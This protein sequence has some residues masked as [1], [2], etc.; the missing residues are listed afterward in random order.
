MTW[1]H[2]MGS[3]LV[4]LL[5]IGIGIYSGKHV[6]TS[7]NSNKGR[8][9]TTGLVTGALLGTLVGGSSTI[10]T[11]QLAYTY[12]FSAWWF[13]L[14]GGIGL[15]ALGT[16]FAKPLYCSGITT[17][18]EL[19][20]NEY[21]KRTGFIS[22]LLNSIGILLAVVAQIISG[23]ALITAVT[24]F[25]TM[26][27][28]ILIIVL[29][30]FYAFSGGS[31]G[32]GYVGIVKTVLIFGLVV[33]CGMLAITDA[34]GLG[35]FFNN[36]LLPH[37]TYFNLFARG[38]TVDLG[39][40]LSLL[41]GVLTTQSYLSAFLMA[42]S[43]KVA[44][45]GALLGALL[46][47]IIGVL[48][49]FVGMYMTLNY[50]DIDAKMA[51]P[52]FIMEKIPSGLAGIMLGTLLIVV[53]GTGA[54]LSMGVTS[55]SCHD[56]YKEYI[57]KQAN[58]ERLRI[59]SRITQT[60]ILIG[61]SLLTLGNMGDLILGWSFMSMG[62]RGSVTF[63]PLFVTLFVRKKISSKYAVSAM[64]AGAFFTLIGKGILPSYIDSIFLGIMAATILIM[65][66][67]WLPD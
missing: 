64:V 24:S 58:P 34:G 29:M 52:V 30:L 43:L 66:G 18:S 6:G 31:L 40:G 67:Y 12:G 51:L 62:L 11:A 15:L 41:V 56:I 47:A 46:S 3:A 17:F 38:V 13:T 65:I 42:K 33:I 21:G 8:R 45:A 1:M 49:I 2:Y 19:F 4:I 55:I 60:I 39:A 27:G 5:I 44:R 61:C 10:G 59:V 36:P 14:G 16:V 50:P 37:E 25:T 48:G 28:T 57:H 7:S 63:V 23:V 26:E 32:A 20:V 35:V 53:V 22:A 54:G 9:A